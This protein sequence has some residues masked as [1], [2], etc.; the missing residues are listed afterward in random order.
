[1]ERNGLNQT[2]IPW[3]TIAEV[4]ITST[5]I[6]MMRRIGWRSNTKR[7]NICRCETVQQSLHPLLRQPPTTLSCFVSAMRMLLRTTMYIYTF[8]NLPY[9]H[10]DMHK[11][12]YVVVSLTCNINRDF[13]FARMS[14]AIKTTFKAR[15]TERILQSTGRVFLVL[16]GL[17]CRGV[18][19]E[20]YV[21]LL[22]TECF[23][24][25]G[26][27]ANLLPHHIIHSKG[28][29]CHYHPNAP[30]PPCLPHRVW[31]IDEIRKLSCSLTGNDAKECLCR[32]YIIFFLALL[33]W[34]RG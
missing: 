34:C 28:K 29:T 21:P 8:I 7:W 15:A 3:L 1:M 23:I 26:T 20:V 5:R 18:T 22:A 4:N 33:P 17:E 2:R 6:L 19:L 30:A 27:N 13:S 31:Y 16:L 9:I 14:F 10:I 25:S 32:V 11:N 12:V 24:V